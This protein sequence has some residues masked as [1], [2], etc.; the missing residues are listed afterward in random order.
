MPNDV[1][2]EATEIRYRE[3]FSGA[4]IYFSLN[5]KNDL[6]NRII[7]MTFDIFGDIPNGN[8]IVNSHIGHFQ[9]HPVGIMQFTV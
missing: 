8:D 6:R 2:F 7:D 9:V 4:L 5:G 3:Y 1:I